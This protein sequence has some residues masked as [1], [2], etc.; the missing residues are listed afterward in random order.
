MKKQTNF[1]NNTHQPIPQKKKRNFKKSLMIMYVTVMLTLSGTI[2][3]HAA[4]AGA[5]TAA[6]NTLVD[7]IFWVAGIAVAAAGGIPGIIK[8]VQGQADEDPRGR[9]AGIASLVVTGAGVAALVVVRNTL[10]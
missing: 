3:A 5:D 10:F 6:Y 4:P 2:S 1:Q 7:V 9:N 8:I